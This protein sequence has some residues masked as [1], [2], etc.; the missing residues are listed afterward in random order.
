M[1]QMC[2]REKK[3]IKI[4]ACI[5]I[6]ILMVQ[7]SNVQKVYAVTQSEFD[8]KLS[9]LQSQYPNYSVWN[10]RFDNG[11]QCFGFAHMMG[12]NVFGTMPSTWQRGYD[13]YSVKPGDLIQ[14][15]NTSGQGHTVFVTAVS[16]NTITFVDCNGNGNYSGSTKVRKNGVLWG[17]TIQ[18]GARI[19]GKYAFS[20]LL[21]SNGIQ[22]YVDT[23][24]TSYAGNYIC[25]SR[26]TLNIRDGHGGAVIGSIPSGA[27]V[28]VSKADGTWAHVSYNGINGC[29][30]MQY[31]QRQQNTLNYRLHVWISDTDMGS[32]PEHF[33]KGKSYY[34]CY[35]ILDTD[36]GKRVDIDH[37]G[38]NYSVSEVFVYP[39]GSKSDPCTYG[40]DYNWYRSYMGSTGQYK[41]I[42]S[43]TG[44]LNVSC[45]VSW[46]AEYSGNVTLKASTYSVNLNIP[47]NTSQRVTLT[48]EGEIPDNC[49]LSKD[50][51]GNGFS[52][53][54]DGDWNGWSHD[55]VITG[56]GSGSGVIIV[57]VV[58]GKNAS[59][60]YGTIKIYVNVTKE[61]K[62]VSAMSGVKLAG[63]ASDALRI[64][65]NT[66]SSASGYIIE[67]YKDGNWSRIAKISGANTYRIENLES[68][69]QYNFRVC[70]YT[71]DDGDEVYG[72]YA[73]VSG[74][75]NP[76][77]VTGVKIGGTAK[78]A[79]RIN[80][81]QNI[82]ASGYIIEKYE[83]GKWN[84]IA[85]IADANTTTYRV[86]N[87]KSA[88]TYNFRIKA[89]DFDGSVPIYSEYQNISGKTNS[90]S[91]TSATVSNVTG[92]KI[93]GRAADA[94][95]INWN[96][97][98]GVSGYI[99]EKYENGKWIRIARIADANTQTYRVEGLKAS[100]TYKFRIEAFSFNGKTPLY[101]TYAYI[102]G[103]TNPAVAAGVCIGG[104]AKDALR[105]NWNK[106]NGASGYII[107][108]YDNGN[109][110]RVARIADA[111]TQTYRV[112]KLKSNTAYVFRVR[113]FDFDGSTP[114]Y[115]GSQYVTGSTL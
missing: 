73:Y 12:Y 24:S 65:W 112:E 93:G 109:W 39:D 27:V 82:G 101:S 34:L 18:K 16:G 89:F 71:T 31:L 53:K 52:A 72:S 47:G 102:N 115:S 60:K 94:L 7:L 91:N 8:A 45:E 43:V 70:G 88:S 22:P 26:T 75:T 78:D 38:L 96:K 3:W 95:R 74:I 64:N 83:N 59:V 103:R 104:T 23:C 90:A 92:V 100:T 49:A 48:M 58:D 28:Y 11:T 30:S 20:Y 13:I 21:V 35:E 114:L 41:G 110:I 56:E 66:N 105:V 106:V 85:R 79:L 9:Q 111:N 113:S 6:S 63:R 97:I 4:I 87:L 98:N 29:A 15:G 19:W 2:R 33:Y 44:D 68:S 40:N 67:Q 50:S 99:I 54:W 69:R 61:Q 36:T 86:E 76:K 32:V 84:R 62:T 81:S 46:N 17:N 57:S 55:M 51:S 42:V 108:K 80:W 37:S 14:Y 10:G 25:T 77:S 107:E 1:K 5:M